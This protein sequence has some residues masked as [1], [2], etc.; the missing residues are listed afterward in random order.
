MFILLHCFFPRGVYVFE[1]QTY[2]PTAFF[3]VCLSAAIE[4]PTERCSVYLEWRTLIW[5]TLLRFFTF[6]KT[7][8]WKY[9]FQAECSGE[10]FVNQWFFRLPLMTHQRELHD[11]AS[12]ISL[13][14]GSKVS[15]SK[16]LLLTGM[17]RLRPV[18][19]ILSQ[20]HVFFC[21]SFTLALFFEQFSEI[22]NVTKILCVY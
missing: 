11:S 8:L 14:N 5:N 2:F 18:N 9:Y 7:Y 6:R 1:K 17:F 12:R 4:P 10:F 19:T 15:W 21:N 22:Q 13:Q 20:K 16:A 3:S